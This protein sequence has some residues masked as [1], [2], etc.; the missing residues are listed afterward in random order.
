MPINHDLLGQAT[1]SPQSKLKN[2]HASHEDI[3]NAEAVAAEALAQ[4]EAAEQ[5]AY[6]ASSKTGAQL[7]DTKLAQHGAN[8]SDA[9]EKQ[10]AEIPTPAEEMAMGVKSFEAK[11][12][13]KK[14]GPSK[15]TLKKRA[16]EPMPIG[17]ITEGMVESTRESKHGD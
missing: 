14:K 13:K 3:A 12:Q 1:L 7:Q 16:A 9:M 4:A 15:A 6:H 2:A 8:A 10:L 17:F 11:E 5:R